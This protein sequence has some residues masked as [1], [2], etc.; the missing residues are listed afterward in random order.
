M[1]DELAVAVL[2]ATDGADCLLVLT[3]WDEFS[4]TNFKTI[5]A[6]MKNR[7]IIDCVGI[8]DG[9]SAV[10]QGFHYVSIGHSND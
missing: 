9:K 6:Q 7:V 1:E 2:D 5:G 10:N 3:D 8:L 4:D